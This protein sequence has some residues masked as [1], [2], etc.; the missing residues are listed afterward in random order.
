MGRA[1]SYAI[2]FLLGAFCWSVWSGVRGKH[3]AP[4]PFAESTGVDREHKAQPA[5]ARS[6]AVR[7]GTGYRA[8]FEV[9]VTLPPKAL[10]RLP[11]G[12]IQIVGHWVLK[13]EEDRI[14]VQTGVPIGAQRL[15]S[16]IIRCSQA[17]RMCE[18]S[19][20]DITL[21]VLLPLDDPLKYEI[22]SWEPGRIVA[23]MD[24]GFHEAQM[25]LNIGFPTDQP[26]VFEFQAGL[27]FHREP[28]PGRGRVFE[29]FVLE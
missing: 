5:A 25:L 26:A 11:D 23:Q 17:K 7:K 12:T 27:E 1:A 21:G 24:I 2:V 6:A 10:T 9:D 14:G 3:L 20:A 18:E 4:A 8:A 28:S 29:R 19:R 13:A 16:I 15:N 22:I